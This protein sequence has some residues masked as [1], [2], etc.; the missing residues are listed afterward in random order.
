MR[1]QSWLA[2]GVTA[3]APGTE[4]PTSGGYPT[5]GTFSEGLFFAQVSGEGRVRKGL[6]LRG[7]RRVSVRNAKLPHPFGVMGREE[8]LGVTLGRVWVSRAW[9]RVSAE[10]VSPGPQQ[11]WGVRPEGGV[12]SLGWEG[13]GVAL[14]PGIRPVHGANSSGLGVQTGRHAVSREAPPFP[15]PPPPPGVPPTQLVGGFSTCP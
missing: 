5:C 13:Q 7:Q 8:P 11:S 14:L 12:S 10:G 4:P 6:R 2:G 15:S 3:A 9:P 1:R